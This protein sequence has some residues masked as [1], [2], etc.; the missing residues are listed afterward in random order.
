MDRGMD[1]RDARRPRTTDDR[2]HA[3]EREAEGERPPASERGV[4][5]EDVA[6]SDDAD[7]KD[8]AFGTADSSLR[9]EI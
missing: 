7:A 3:V 6:K 2:G 8:P 5:S 4:T 9:T 1:K